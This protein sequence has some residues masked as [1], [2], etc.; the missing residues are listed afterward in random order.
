MYACIRTSL[1]KHI[2]SEQAAISRRYRWRDIA[3]HSRFILHTYIHTYICKKPMYLPI[4]QC[5]R[6][7]SRTANIWMFRLAQFTRYN[8]SAHTYIHTYIHTYY[9]LTE[10]N[11]KL[12][13]MLKLQSSI[14]KDM[15]KE[16]EVLVKSR[17]IHTYIHLH[18]HTH[19]RLCSH[20]TY[21]SIT[22][23]LSTYVHT[24]IP[25]IEETFK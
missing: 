22:E 5:W 19:I 10:E 21:D 3:Q 6:G 13:S 25:F 17:Y 7:S 24:Y 14:N 4:N 2:L 9:Q 12:E 8:T 18:I 1:S 15:Q 16:L 23:S 11:E 20:Q